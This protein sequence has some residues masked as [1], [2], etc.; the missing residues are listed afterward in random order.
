MSLFYAYRVATRLLGPVL[1]IYLQ[2]RKK[3]GKEDAG[4]I[5]ERFGHASALRPKG[6]L[7]WIHGASV[8]ESLSSLPV[9][10]AIRARFP[11]TSILVTTGTVTSAAMMY[12]RLPEGVIHQFIPI[13]RQVCVARFLH[14]WKP[15]AAL[16][17]ESDFWPNILTKAKKAGTRLALLNGR[18]SARSFK[19]YSRFPS[20]ITPVISAFDLILTQGSKETE[21]FVSLGGKDVRAVG[22]L[23]FAAP[24]LPVE[25]DALTELQS[26]IGTRPVWLAASTFEGEEL[27]CAQV[28]QALSLKHEGLLTVIVPRHP[29]R[30]D[31]IEADLIAQGLR[32]ARRSLGHKITEDID[33]YLGDTMGEMGLYYRIA[34]VC[35][36]GK[37]LCASG[38]QN[39]LEPARLGCAILHGPDMSNFSEISQELLTAHACRPVADRDDLTRQ[40]DIL[41]T[42]PEKASA[43]ANAALAYANSKAEVL[44]R[45]ID[46]ITP[47]LTGEVANARA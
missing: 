35:L 6:K 3:R 40:I 16:W 18:I 33:I 38:G 25:A 19:S 44:E 47:L 10:D 4:R 1:G 41:L 12:Q 34:P 36:I 20:F 42:Q 2:R 24:P 5:G 28:H 45:T 39:P 43:L 31:E 30:A 21:R 32:V 29:D 17:L 27:A 8:G 46:A 11:E 7:V 26:Q 23:K 9:I 15:D 13:D 14:H 37:S 22:N